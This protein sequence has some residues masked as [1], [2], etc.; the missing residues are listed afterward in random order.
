MSGNGH[1]RETNQICGSLWRQ[2]NRELRLSSQRAY[3]SNQGGSSS[4]GPQL[5]LICQPALG[6][7][8]TNSHRPA[9]A[10]T[11]VYCAKRSISAWERKTFRSFPSQYGYNPL[12][13]GSP[14]LESPKNNEKSASV[15]LIF[16]GNP[17][18]LHVCVLSCLSSNNSISIHIR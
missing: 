7:C 18:W 14:D 2:G 17:S 12:L 9:N 15:N 6:T 8:R 5:T 16:C 10:L 1:W 11:K 13:A 3:K 4:T